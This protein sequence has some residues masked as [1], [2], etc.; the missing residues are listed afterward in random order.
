MIV[1]DQGSQLC[2]AA[3]LSQRDINWDSVR[4]LTANTGTRWI[5]T[6]RGF[7][8]RNGTAERA[9]G[10]AKT[11]LEHQLDG[12]RSLDFS[13]MDE[14]FLRVAFIVNSRPIGVR[15]LKEDDYHTIT[16][17]DLLL[18]RAAGPQQHHE[19]EVP[20]G[21]LDGEN[22]PDR[23]LIQQEMICEKWWKQWSQLAFPLFAP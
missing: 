17:N 6:E 8:W 2:S 5:F 9:V 14:L 4:S 12:H 13:Q 7:P 16:L 23:F 3:K 19:S 20:Q 22:E 15:F 21:D 18:G 11:T 1:S 10:L